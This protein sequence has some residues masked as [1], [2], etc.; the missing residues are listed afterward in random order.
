MVTVD[1]PVNE[2]LLVSENPVIDEATLQIAAD[3]FDRWCKELREKYPTYYA[4]TFVKRGV[5]YA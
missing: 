2:K 5:S 1:Q 3:D 4:K